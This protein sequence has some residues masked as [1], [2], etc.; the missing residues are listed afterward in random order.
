MKRMTVAV[1]GVGRV[2]LPLA[3]V[4]ADGG[5]KVF[6]IGRTIDK[7]NSLLEGK[8][9]FID[10]GAEL[11]K[12]YVKKSFFPT[13]SY[14][15]IKESKIIILTLGTPIDENMNPVLDQIDTCL[16]EMIP[17]LKKGQLIILRSTVSPRTTIYVKEKIESL[18][19]LKV[20]KNIFLA[21]CPERIAEGKSI[22]ETK[23]IPQIIGGV[24]DISTEK[25]KI[26]FESLKIK[27][28]TT[29]STTAELAKL[30]TNMYRY[31]N[32]AISNEFLVVAES[33]NRNIHEIV[34]LINTDYKRG[35]LALP[36][37]TAGPC[38]F[39]DGFFL[40]NDNP[41]LDLITASWKINESLPLFLVK[42][43]KERINLKNKKVLILGLA[44][45][46]EI[47]D[48]RESLSFKIRKALLRE[49]AKVVLHDPFVKEY[50]QQEVLNNLDEALRGIDVLFV[51]TRHK[52]YEQQAGLILKKIHKKVYICDVWNTFGINKL[53]FTA[54]QISLL[55]N[56][57]NIK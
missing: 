29:D 57:E 50:S 12:K 41:Y 30:F 3:L 48:I 55:K 36:G 34:N 25:A 42:K 11:L 18:T 39:K 53:V 49:H 16:N 45:K 23:S 6:G 28:L 56:K 43:I 47:D 24:N 2:G 32:F 4:L 51:A 38:L 35:G 20:G 13:V 40:I 19:K 44:F 8:M 37:L 9:P 15:P 10:E 54:N 7:I 27:C 46:P 21:F 52:I 33:F 14:E 22:T 1:I 26:F 31:I 5:Y 17:Y